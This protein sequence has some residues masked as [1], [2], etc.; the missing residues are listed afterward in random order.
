MF[1]VKLNTAL[2]HAPSKLVFKRGLEI[3][4]GKDQSAS[5]EQTRLPMDEAEATRRVKELASLLKKGKW[6]YFLTI[7]VN[8][9]ETPGVRM[10]TRAIRQLAHGYQRM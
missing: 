9:Q 10:I 6:N 8:D 3:F 5:M 1:D 7:T 2:N 4:E